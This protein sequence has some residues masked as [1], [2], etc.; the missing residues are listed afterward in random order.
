M[1]CAVDSLWGSTWDCV[2]QVE[3]DGTS[4]GSIMESGKRQ[5]SHSSCGS[6]ARH[7]RPADGEEET[8]WLLSWLLCVVVRVGVVLCV[9]IEVRLQAVGKVE[10]RWW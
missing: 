1:F 7:S 8:P 3:S 5:V 4:G 6:N 9:S 10:Q 2:G